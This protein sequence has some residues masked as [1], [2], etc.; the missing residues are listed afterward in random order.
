MTF[1]VRT[2]GGDTVAIELDFA[3]CTVGELQN[4][5]TTQLDIIPLHQRL[6]YKYQVLANPTSLLK[7]FD[8]KPLSYVYLL[9]L[10]PQ[11]V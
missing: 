5:I 4:A 9:I 7:D 11:L 1:Y 10:N 3:T 2:L 8:I 6:F